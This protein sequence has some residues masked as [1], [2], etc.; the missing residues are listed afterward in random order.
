[1]DSYLLWHATN[2]GKECGIRLDVGKSAQSY[3]PIM[4]KPSCAQYYAAQG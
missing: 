3:S 1:M 4:Q 2:M